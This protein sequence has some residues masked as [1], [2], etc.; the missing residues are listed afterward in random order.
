MFKT[1]QSSQMLMFGNTTVEYESLSNVA[2]S[3]ETFY[4]A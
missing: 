1:K 2:G 3:N 4:Y